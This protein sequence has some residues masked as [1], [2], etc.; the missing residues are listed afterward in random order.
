MKLSELDKSTLPVK[1]VSNITK[2]IFTVFFIGDQ[3]ALIYNAL[4]EAHAYRIDADIDEWSLCETP[5]QKVALYAYKHKDDTR[6][7][8]RDIF[9]KDDKDFKYSL[10]CHEGTEYKRLL[11]SETEI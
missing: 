11:W 10:Y 2:G 5:K 4:G 8:L 7:T 6:W 3:H 1:V 9:F